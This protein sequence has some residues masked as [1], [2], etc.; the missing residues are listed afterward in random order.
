[1]NNFFVILFALSM[2]AIP[3]FLVVMGIGL[4]R[5]KPVKKAK[6]GLLGAAVVWL[7]SLVGFGCTMPEVILPEKLEIVVLQEQEVYD[8]HS[9]IEVDIVAT[10]ENASLETVK[11][12]VSKGN[13]EFSDGLIRVGDTAGEVEV[14]VYAGEVTSEKVVITVIDKEA[15]T[16]AAAEKAVREAEERAA[17]AEK[18]AKEAEEK[19]AAA[20]KEAKEAEEKAAAAEKVAKEAE[21]KAAAEKAAK[22]AEEKA[23]AEK[24][25]REAEEKAAAAEKAAREAE[26]KAAAEKAAKEAE[27]Q[28]AAEKAAKEAEAQAAAEQA[29]REAAEKAAAEQAAI[30]AAI[31]AAQQ[32]SAQAATQ[33]SNVPQQSGGGS[34]AVNDKNGKIHK[35]GECPATGTGDNAM[36]IPVYFNTY[37][38]AE[39]Y[40]I[41]RHPK[42]NKRKCG[43]CW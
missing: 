18:E 28:V 33:I 41:Q 29:A 32:P 17:V 3:A 11:Y 10:P 16:K 5:K 22:E 4:V 43:N 30:A 23:A 25:A 12:V 42:Q 6:K 39:A 35:V 9:N 19:A 14:Y 27:A 38:E 24:A 20:E 26:E 21:E 8:I 1:M 13:A 36:D 34:Y 37:E 40:S 15:E 2:L 7:A 31:A